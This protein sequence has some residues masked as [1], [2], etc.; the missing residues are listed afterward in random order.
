MPYDI[1]VEG[2]RGERIF[3]EVKTTRMPGDIE[4]P[5]A[6]HRDFFELSLA[7]LDFARVQGE[8]YLLYRVFVGANGGT[9]VRRLRDP[10]SSLRPGGLGLLMV[11]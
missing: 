3:I 10:V 7:E 1:A 8:R 2:D 4:R 6:H 5:S 9:T 11:A